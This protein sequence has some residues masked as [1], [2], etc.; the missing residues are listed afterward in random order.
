MAN[1][2]FFNKIMMVTGGIGNISEEDKIELQFVEEKRKEFLRD[3]LG[4]DNFKKELNLICDKE[5]LKDY[6]SDDNFIREKIDV[7]CDKSSKVK[8][9]SER[10]QLTKTEKLVSKIKDEN[11]KPIIDRDSLLNL[12]KKVNNEAI[13]ELLEIQNKI[14][15]KI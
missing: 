14:L 15:F 4:D 5:F 10:S 13:K 8:S 6:L 1:E 11:M 3:Y 9:I 7:I 2:N 12:T